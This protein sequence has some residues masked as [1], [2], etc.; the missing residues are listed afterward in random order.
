LAFCFPATIANHTLP[1][2]EISLPPN[3]GG[4]VLSIPGWV[5]GA[6]TEL[7]WG[8]GGMDRDGNKPWWFPSSSSTTTTDA[9]ISLISTQLDRLEEDMSLPRCLLELLANCPRDRR[10]LLASRLYLIGGMADCPGFSRRLI[11]EMQRL[12]NEDLDGGRFSNLRGLVN[13]LKC[14]KT[15]LTVSQAGHRLSSTLCGWLG[16]SLMLSLPASNTAGGALVTS[17]ST[18][19]SSRLSLSLAS[20]GLRSSTQQSNSIQQQL[21][22]GWT[23][24]REEFM[25]S[26][27]AL[28]DCLWPG[29]NDTIN[30]PSSS[31]KKRSFR[32]HWHYALD[33]G[34]WHQQSNNELR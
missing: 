5:R 24:S 15:S 19:G 25:Q 8:G 7:F 26:T 12:I 22:S 32:K 4:G 6:C 10:K 13:D 1:D 27:K 34:Q 2:V 29:D 23:I 16:A 28:P 21:P 17:S 20:L 9:H 18:I 14:V 30:K 31:I 3:L 11:N 33:D